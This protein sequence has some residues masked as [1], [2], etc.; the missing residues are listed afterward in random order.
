[1][2]EINFVTFETIDVLVDLHSIARHMQYLL[3]FYMSYMSKILL[4]FSLT[5]TLVLLI[6]QKICN[7]CVCI[8]VQF[9]C[10]IVEIQKKPLI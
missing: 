2:F 3:H 5:G 6:S 4:Q 10:T 7:G 8:N 1:M 9:W